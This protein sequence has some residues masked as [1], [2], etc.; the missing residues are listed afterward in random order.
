[1]PRGSCWLDLV[2]FLG[3]DIFALRAERGTKSHQALGGLKASD[4]FQ[5]GAVLAELR[6]DIPTQPCLPSPGKS[7]NTPG[8]AK[9]VAISVHSLLAP[10]SVSGKSSWQFV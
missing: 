1:M 9:L 2:A 5:F 4:G 10:Q 6:E 8:V 3:T 7:P